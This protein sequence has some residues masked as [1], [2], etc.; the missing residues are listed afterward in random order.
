MSVT[1]PSTQEFGYCPCY[2]DE[3]VGEIVARHNGY[4]CGVM[5]TKLKKNGH[6]VGCKCRPCLGKR[7]KAKGQRA[8]ARAHKRLGGEGMTVND[9]LFHSYS[10]NVSVESKTGAQVPAY[11]SKFVQGEWWHS[12]IRQASKKVPVGADAMPAVYIE[13]TPSVAFLV[14]DV[15]GKGLRG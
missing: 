4:G 2:E 15:S 7:N 10:I 5:G 13:F 14:V 1:S 12:A 9:D 11:F 8:N 6:L 3:R